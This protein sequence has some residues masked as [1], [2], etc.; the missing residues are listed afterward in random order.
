MRERLEAAV[1]ADE[2][3]HHQEQHVDDATSEQCDANTRPPPLYLL[4]RAVD[5]D[6]NVLDIFPGVVGFVKAQLEASYRVRL[7][8]VQL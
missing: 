6:G 8:L 3:H 2:Q 7:Q 1:V 4:L 5:N